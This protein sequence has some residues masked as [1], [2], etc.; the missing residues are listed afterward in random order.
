MDYTST[1]SIEH[2]FPVASFLISL[3]FALFVFAY[4]HES[5]MDIKEIQN[6]IF[7][8]A[9]SDFEQQ[10]V[11]Y[12]NIPNYDIDAFLWRSLTH[13][14]RANQLQIKN[15]RNDYK[16]RIVHYFST[17]I[18]NLREGNRWSQV[19]EG[20]RKHIFKMYE[21]ARQYYPYAEMS[22]KDEFIRMLDEYMDKNGQDEQQFYER[23]SK[24]YGIEKSQ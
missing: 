22:H 11:E 15:I 21:I 10:R 2:V 3:G 4:S 23:L 18:K 24:R 8:H 7:L 13:L 16:S 14:I 19:S 5:G 12:I 17:T 9:I 1:E 20:Q 6:S